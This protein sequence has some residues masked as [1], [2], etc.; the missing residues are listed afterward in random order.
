MN[1]LKSWLKTAC[2]ALGLGLAFLQPQA[3]ADS[4]KI[5]VVT[6]GQSSDSYWGVVKKGVDG[7]RALGPAQARLTIW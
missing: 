2:V 6:H 4:I 5:A 1:P 7:S 3:Y